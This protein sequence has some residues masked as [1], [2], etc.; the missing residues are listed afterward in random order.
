MITDQTSNYLTCYLSPIMLCLVI[1][2]LFCGTNITKAQTQGE[3][4][5][6]NT[7][8]IDPKAVLHIEN[9][10]DDQGLPLGFKLPIYED[11]EFINLQ[12]S[13][14]SKGI[15]YFG[16][17]QNQI[18]NSSTFDGVGIIEPIGWGMHGNKLAGLGLGWLDFSIGTKDYV[19]LTLLPTVLP[20]WFLNPA[21]K[22]LWALPSLPF[23]MP[24]SKFIPPI[25]GFYFHE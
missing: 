17:N 19:G 22:L 4:V 5:G 9:T 6:I 24:Y 15:L 1:C 20:V 18:L 12:G 7:T 23:Q 14:I 3:G 8:S 10:Y 2:T 13:S 21:V 11:S 16:Q 25:R